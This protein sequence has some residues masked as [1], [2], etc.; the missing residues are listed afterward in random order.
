M[1]N[2][3]FASKLAWLFTLTL[4]LSLLIGFIGLGAIKQTNQGLRTVYQDRVIPLAQLKEIVDA[5]A[6]D[7]IDAANKAN[8]GLFTPAQAIESV[9]RAQRVIKKHWDDYLATLLTPEESLLIEQAQVMIRAADLDTEKFLSALRA[10]DPGESVRGKL[11]EFD[12]PLYQTIDPISEQISLLVDLQLRV[13]GEE[14]AAAQMR[15]KRTFNSVVWLIILGGGGMAVVVGFIIRR[16]TRAL[17]RAAHELEQAAH[18]TSS[19]SGQVSSGSQTIANGATRQAATLEETGAALEEISGMMKRNTDSADAA[20][21]AAG[22]AHSEAETGSTEVNDLRGALGNLEAS[23]AE[24]SKIIRMIDEIAFQ[25]NLLALNAAVEAARAGEAG[26]GFAVVADEVRA[27][28]GRCSEAARD[29]AGKISQASG[30]SRRS[31]ELGQQVKA[32]FENIFVAVRDIE[33]RLSEISVSTREQGVGIDQLN[34]AVRQLDQETQAS[35]ASAEEAAAASEELNAQA[36]ELAGIVDALVHLVDAARPRRLEGRRLGPAADY[37]RMNAS[38]RPIFPTPSSA[39]KS[40][41]GAPGSSL[42]EKRA[43]GH[44]RIPFFPPLTRRAT[45]PRGIRDTKNSTLCSRPVGEGEPHQKM[46][47]M[48]ASRRPWSASGPAG[49]PRR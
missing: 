38:S 44:R 19:A 15:Y 30:D 37:R 6:V 24:I 13:A 5:Y 45:S 8:A 25:T 47:C 2:V 21:A 34:L 43:S 9:E 46:T 36:T 3:S 1:R 31:V 28:A 23:S 40:R 27:L 7:L 22:S 32:R 39:R 35:A 41:F 4:G 16:A 17:S 33:A 29:S 48:R 12:G 11:D 42:R 14:Y 49:S 10:L 18:A 20:H 26:A